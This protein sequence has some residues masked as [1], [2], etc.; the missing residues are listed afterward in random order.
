MNGQRMNQSVA[1]TSFITSTSRRRLNS[2]KRIVFDTNS[3][4]AST[5]KEVRITIAH[6]TSL[7]TVRI[8]SVWSFS[9][10]T[11]SIDWSA[12]WRCPAVSRGASELRIAP[13]LSGSSG[14]TRKVS[15]SGFEPRSLYASGL[16]ADSCL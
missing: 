16:R 5:S 11:R 4:L 2:D 9:L 3:T 10:R 13:M 12:S 15:G 7:V 8:L 1:P 6:F 14:V